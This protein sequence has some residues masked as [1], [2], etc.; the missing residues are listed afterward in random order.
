MQDVVKG[1][2]IDFE[3]P[4]RSKTFEEELRPNI[5]VLARYLQKSIHVDIKTQREEEEI[6]E[7]RVNFFQ[8][9]LLPKVLFY[10]FAYFC[11]KGA[12]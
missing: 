12:L 7:V 1:E 8:A 9:W 3:E 11:A 5:D 2:P 4:L 6:E 10:A